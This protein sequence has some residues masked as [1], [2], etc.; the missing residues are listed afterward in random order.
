MRPGLRISS[1]TVRRAGATLAMAASFATASPA[2][3]SSGPG[4]PEAWLHDM[5]R[6]LVGLSGLPIEVHAPSDGRVRPYVFYA[7]LATAWRLSESGTEVRRAGSVRAVMTER[8]RFVAVFWGNGE[9]A[10]LGWPDP[11]P[12]IIPMDDTPHPLAEF[13]DRLLSRTLG[14]PLGN[15]PAGSRFVPVVTSGPGGVVERPDNPARVTLWESLGDLIAITHPDGIRTVHGWREVDAALE[16][17][18]E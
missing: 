12:E 15:L 5:E 13:H 4:S 10:S 7:P 3:G 2:F 9:I 14:S 6:R 17:G 18:A 1:P 16:G 8:G 11:L